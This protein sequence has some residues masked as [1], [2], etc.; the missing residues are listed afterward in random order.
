MA[1]TLLKEYRLQGYLLVRSSLRSYHVVFNRY[2]SWK[3]ITE[4]LFSRYECSRYA[5]Q[6]MQNGHLTLRISPK[7]GKNKPEILL[8][9]GKTDKLIRDYLEVF[10]KFRKVTNLWLQSKTETISCFWILYQIILYSFRMNFWN[11]LFFRSC[12]FFSFFIFALLFYSFFSFCRF[13]LSEFFRCIIHKIH[14]LF[15]IFL[16]FFFLFSVSFV[17]YLR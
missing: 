9:F 2:L 8:T 4:I 5:V 12:F 16:F 1:E 6:Q 14:G 17:R 7:N 10:E 13:Y 15:L 3:K 11:S